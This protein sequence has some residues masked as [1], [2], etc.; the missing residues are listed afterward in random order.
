MK[1]ILEEVQL[2]ILQKV[3]HSEQTRVHV[4]K[5]T[6]WQIETSLRQ[7]VGYSLE[8]REGYLQPGDL[9]FIPPGTPHSFHYPSRECAWI[10]LKFDWPMP[11]DAVRLPEGGVLHKGLL[12]D[13]FIA[14]LQTIGTSGIMQPFEK[15]FVEGLVRS[16]FGHLMSEEQEW[17]GDD[18]DQTLVRTVKELVRERG[19]KP[20]R[21]EE[22]AEITSYSRSH[23]S[24]QFT[25]LTGENLKAYIDRVRLEKAKELLLYGEGAMAEI[26]EALQFK[27]LFAF[28]R[29]FKRGTGQSPREFR[30]HE[31]LVRGRRL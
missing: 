9:L 20:I 2:L 27:D 10:T 23:L 19:G 14:A 13:T 8:E 11:L 21:I 15:R 12:G 6:F 24:K 31:K 17:G 28:S 26:A 22:L 30:K 5:H 25:R 3:E 1:G 29:F 16:L 7:E 18:P 4:H